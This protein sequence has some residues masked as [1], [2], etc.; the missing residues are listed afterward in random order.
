MKPTDPSTY[1]KGG[2]SQKQ[3]ELMFGLLV[4]VPLITNNRE[5]AS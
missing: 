4:L 1:G 3:Q 2:E 5:M